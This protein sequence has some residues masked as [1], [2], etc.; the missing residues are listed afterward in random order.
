MSIVYWIVLYVALY[1]LGSSESKSRVERYT[2]KYI[3]FGSS[4]A[5]YIWIFIVMSR[6][7]FSN[8]KEFDEWQN[9]TYH[10]SNCMPRLDH[11][12]NLDLHVLN[13]DGHKYQ[14][15]LQIVKQQKS[16]RERRQ[17]AWYWFHMSRVK[18]QPWIYED[19]WILYITYMFWYAFTLN[20]TWR[21][22]TTKN[23][24][25][26][27]HGM[28]LGCITRPPQISRSRPLAIVQIGSQL[29]IPQCI[30]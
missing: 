4:A 6:D 2:L 8:I 30:N 21:P 9:F 7:I 25:S 26:V 11:I 22:M 28:A 29:G 13:Q 10:D 24:I 14:L 5:M 3:A 23:S 15:Q 19:T 18:F 1:Y 12:S 20:Y 17:D 16:V 27:F